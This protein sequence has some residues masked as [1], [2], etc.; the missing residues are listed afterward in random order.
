[1]EQQ[2]GILDLIHL[3][4]KE[5]LSNG[6]FTNYTLFRLNNR[7]F[8]DIHNQN[9]SQVFS[10][11]RIW[12]LLFWITFII[13]MCGNWLVVYVVFRAKQMQTVTNVYLLNLAVVDVLYLMST[14]PNTSYWTNYW[15]VGDFMC[16]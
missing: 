3:T 12:P 14:I 11:H 1:M 2:T 6:D 5:T 8:T 7:S 10:R 15:P 16:K 4:Q 9:S 13:G